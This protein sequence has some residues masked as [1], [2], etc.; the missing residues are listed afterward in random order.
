[1]KATWTIYW[2]E[3]RNSNQIYDVEM[4]ARETAIPFQPFMANAIKYFWLAQPWM[5]KK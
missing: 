2:I 5:I 4:A 3:L 1:M